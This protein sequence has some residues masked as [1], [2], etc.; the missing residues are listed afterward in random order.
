M[1]NTPRKSDQIIDSRNTIAPSSDFL[2]TLTGKLVVFLLIPLVVCFGL[3]AAL[4]L[5]IRRRRRQRLACSAARSSW[6]SD[7]YVRPHSEKRH[8]SGGW[9]GH[10]GPSIQDIFVSYDQGREQRL[11]DRWARSPEGGMS[12]SSSGSVPPGVYRSP[13]SQSRRLPYDTP[14]AAS[15]RTLPALP[16]GQSMAGS[17]TE[18]G[19]GLSGIL[20]NQGSERSWTRPL[21]SLLGSEYTRS[22]VDHSPR[23]ETNLPPYTPGANGTYLSSLSSGSGSGSGSIT[24]SGQGAG[25]AARSTGGSGLGS[26]GETYTTAEAEKALLY[27]LAHSGQGSANSNVKTSPGRDALTSRSGRFGIADHPFASADY[28]DRSEE[29]ASTIAASEVLSVFGQPPSEHRDSAMTAYS[30]LQHFFTPSPAPL[31]P[32]AP[33]APP[34]PTVPPLRP[35]VNTDL[36]SL[37]HASGPASVLSSMSSIPAHSA[38]PLL[39]QVGAS[40]GVSETSA[41]SPDDWRERYEREERRLRGISSVSGGSGRS[42]ARPDSDVIPFETFMESRA[43]RGL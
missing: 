34:A 16:E 31:V 11:S 43:G 14:A 21:R 22:V 20:G 24:G 28:E 7:I 29:R 35:R 26:S 8:S 1:G 30:H 33:T 42:A 39:R 12:R 18:E 5:F 38:M 32:P 19:A 2:S 4:F 27:T 25:S 10:S 23:R 9:S 3:G 15:G 40:P 36:T 17:P 13:Q 6:S 41:G 37:R